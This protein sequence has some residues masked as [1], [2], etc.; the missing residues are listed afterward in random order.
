MVEV[1]FN[2]GQV[3]FATIGGIADQKINCPWPNEFMKNYMLNSNIF[4]R[5]QSLSIRVKSIFQPGFLL[6]T[7]IFSYC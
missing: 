2:F 3:Q 6:L 4:F 1:F 5:V 7:A